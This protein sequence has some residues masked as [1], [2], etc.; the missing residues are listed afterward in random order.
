MMPYHLLPI[1][2][3]GGLSSVVSVQ[4]GSVLWTIITFLAIA[5]L[6]NK[7]GWKP[8]LSGLKTREETIRKDLETARAEREKAN[9]MLADY[10][11]T[12]AGAKKEASEIIHKAQETA[13]QMLEQE[14]TKAK[15]LADRM[16]ERATQE[17]ERE[18]DQARADLRGYV[19]ELT[20]RAASRIL[21]RVIDAKE[22]ERIILDALKEEA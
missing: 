1:A 9:A 4:P 8:I 2:E 6:I 14:R 20:T 16:V 7:F 5:W 15:E 22:H 12:L 10:Q 19:S 17:I 11:N 13:N 3:G 21:G 18:R